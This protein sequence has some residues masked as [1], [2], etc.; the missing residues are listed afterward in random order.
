MLLRS[1]SSPTGPDAV[2]AIHQQLVRSRETA[3]GDRLDSLQLAWDVLAD[4]P[5]GHPPGRRGPCAG[6][7]G[8]GVR[9]AERACAPGDTRLSARR[10]GADAHRRRAACDNPAGDDAARRRGAGARGG[11][12][13]GCGRRWCW[14]RGRRRGCCMRGR[15]CWS[16]WG[17]RGGV[18]I[19][20]RRSGEGGGGAAAARAVDRGLWPGGGST[21]IR[22]SLLHATHLRA[23][24]PVH[25]ALC[26]P[27][28]NTLHIF[29][30]CQ[31]GAA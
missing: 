1:R 29:R 7:A 18:M 23:R 16:R 19:G 22:R 12:G 3:G 31:I 21:G 9:R 5:G 6:P 2:T 24:G 28:G 14:W 30:A 10:A 8:A 4:S 27:A 17:S 15:R 13:G 11:S 20:R 25:G 26:F